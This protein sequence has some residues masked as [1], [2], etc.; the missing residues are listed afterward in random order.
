MK[1]STKKQETKN[2]L[3]SLIF[4]V[5]RIVHSKQ[6]KKSRFQND[7]LSRI[8]ILNKIMNFLKNTWWLVCQQS[9][10]SSKFSDFSKV[11]SVIESSSPI[12]MHLF[13]GWA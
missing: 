10:T 9:F 5:N 11:S 4:R 2:L 1:N 3:F 6:L 12:K 13:D 8:R 7:S